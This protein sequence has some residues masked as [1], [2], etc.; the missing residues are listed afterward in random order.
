MMGS[1]AIFGVLFFS[2]FIQIHGSNINIIHKEAKIN[3]TKKG[4]N[5]F[6]GSWVYDESY[7]LYERSECP[8]LETQFQCVAR[9]DK[10]YLKYRW[11]PH[12]CKLPRYI[13]HH[14][15]SY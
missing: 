10:L 6:Y 5:F 9:P 7:P 13:T 14:L 2:L 12:G 4:C 8:F 3:V 15:I 1:L 11:Q